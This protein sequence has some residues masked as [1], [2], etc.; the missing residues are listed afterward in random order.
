MLFH[1]APKMSIDAYRHLVYETPRF[2]DYFIDATPIRGIAKL[3][4][5]SRPSSRKA[6]QKIQDLRAIPW[7]F[8]WGQCRLTLPGWFGFGSAVEE[9]L[10]HLKAADK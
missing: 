4:I 10:N 5:G 9:F 3:N 8:S 2:A 1:P 6:T 7:G